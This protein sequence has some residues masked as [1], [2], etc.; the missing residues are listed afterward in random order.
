MACGLV[1]DEDR[2]TRSLSRS[3][4]FDDQTTARTSAPSTIRLH[5]KGLGGRVGRGADLDAT[6]RR[7]VARQRQLDRRAE[8][9]S[10]KAQNRRY[11]LG[12]VHRMCAALDLP[13]AV[14]QEASK[15]CRDGHDA[16]VFVGEGLDRGAAAAVYA[17]CRCQELVRSVEDVAGVARADADQ[18]VRVY[19]KLAVA[20]E[21]ATPLIRP[22]DWIPQV[23][24]ELDVGVQ[25]QQSAMAWAR[26]AEA[27]ENQFSGT[28]PSGI[29]A[30][31]LYLASNGVLTQT[32]I[33]A[34]AGVSPA[35]L[36]K[37]VADLE[38]LTSS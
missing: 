37:R 4:A 20:L 17:A 33:A 7:R 30:A 16:M 5:D 8:A 34:A 13:D 27:H 35:T 19:R 15:I 23:A 25:C 38:A 29:A 3:D 9:P 21:L 2:L 22:T 6:R 1:V 32:A 26:R 18:I 12:E 24:D 31:S 28:A 14:D 10:K 36:R 11:A